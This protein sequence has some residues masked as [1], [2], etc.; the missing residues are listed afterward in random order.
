MPY[1]QTHDG[2]FTYLS[3]AFGEKYHSLFGAMSE[4]KHVFISNGLE[5]YASKNPNTTSVSLL[6]MGTGTGLNLCLTIEWCLKQKFHLD[7][8][9]LEAYPLSYSEVYPD[10]ENESWKRD[11]VNL[12]KDGAVQKTNFSLQLLNVSILDW[13]PNRNYNV[14]FYDAFSPRT[15]PEL[16]T[17]EVFEK[18]FAC[19]SVGGVLS[20]YC[21]MGQVRRNMQLVGFSVERREGPPGKR[22]M[23]VGVKE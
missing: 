2:S 6:E 9:G 19:M 7:Y 20:T 11:V 21:A 5:L 17:I 12:F 18:L 14:V 3:E 4:S 15:Q 16:W 13:L 8:T 23:L 1:I 22:E 10:W